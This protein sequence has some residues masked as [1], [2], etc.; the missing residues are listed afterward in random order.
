MVPAWWHDTGSPETN[1]ELPALTLV[2]ERALKRAIDEYLLMRPEVSRSDLSQAEAAAIVQRELLEKQQE[3]ATLPRMCERFGKVARR[4]KEFEDYPEPEL[5]ASVSALREEIAA[6]ASGPVSRPAEAEAEPSVDGAETRPVQSRS[7]PSMAVCAG[8]LD[9]Q[10]DEPHAGSAMRKGSSADSV[11]ALQEQAIWRGAQRVLTLRGHSD[12]VN[13]LAVL[14]P[15]RVASA[16]GDNTVKVWDLASGQCLATL[17]GHAKCVWALVLFDPRRL[18]SASADFTVKVWDL[19]RSRC[20]VTL[21]GHE[22]W[23]MALAKVSNIR[24]VSAS[25]DLAIKVWDM[26]DESCVITLHIPPS[27]DVR[28][29]WFMDLAVID[30]SHVASASGDR[31]VRVWDLTSQECVKSWEGHDQGV[32]AFAVICS[33]RLASAGFDMIVKVWNLVDQ[34]AECLFTLRGHSGR[35][36]SL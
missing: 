11:T 26:N 3:L 7:A 29:G 1:L 20:A 32:I 5:R 25:S 23:V 24:L 18:V 21:K 36:V 28:T 2:P 14:G 17:T 35:I 30:P 33:D 19:L 22:D 9:R 16:S 13:A 4:L 12:A 8:D 27:M 10:P 15:N 34:N 31:A 6:M